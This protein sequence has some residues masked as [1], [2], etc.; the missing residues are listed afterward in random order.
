MTRQTYDHGSFVGLCRDIHIDIH[1]LKNI[2]R[3]TEWEKA[4]VWQIYEYRK[5]WKL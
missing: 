1:I 2:P 3:E 4:L 5:V